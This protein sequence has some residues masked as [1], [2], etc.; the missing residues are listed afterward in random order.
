MKNIINRFNVKHLKKF[1]HSCSS[2][3]FRL[4]LCDTNTEVLTH[5]VH[6]FAVYDHVEVV[7]GSLVH[8][9]C[10]AL[11]SP[12]NSFGDMGGGV[13]K[14]IDDYF[15][16]KAQQVVQQKIRDEWYGELPV[17]VAMIVEPIPQKTPVIICAPT[18]RIPGNIQGT[19][20]VYVAMRAILRTA[21]KAHLLHV[22]CPGLGT[23]VGGMPHEE[24]ARQMNVAFHMIM[25]EGWKQIL[26]PLQA[27]FINIS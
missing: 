13:D 10:D 7:E 26:H 23:G 12:A 14:V 15:E 1:G 8:I 19:I 27:P 6:E 4:T 2:H 24:A 9:T 18:M 25:M 11:V 5:L 20:N 21:Q 3:Q 22:A 17:G 16:G